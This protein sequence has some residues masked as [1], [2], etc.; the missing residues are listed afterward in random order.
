MR[1]KRSKVEQKKASGKQRPLFTKMLLPLC[2]MN[3]FQIIKVQSSA[4]KKNILKKQGFQIE[5]ILF[6]V[7][8][9]IVQTADF[10]L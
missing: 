2:H 3:F 8:L 9:L 7:I 5:K 1:K 4:I 10:H 6:K